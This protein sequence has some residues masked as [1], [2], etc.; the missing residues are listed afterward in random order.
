[1]DI[2]DYISINKKV[3]QIVGF[4]PTNKVRSFF[5]ISC[6]FPIII[7][8]IIQIYQDWNDL[9]IVLEVRSV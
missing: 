6:M 1:M 5:C 4:Y 7:P 8:Q 3:L 2:E 9:S